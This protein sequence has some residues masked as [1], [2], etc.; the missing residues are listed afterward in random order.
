MQEE[1]LPGS[2]RRRQAVLSFGAGPSSK[3]GGSEMKTPRSA[4]GAK[5]QKTKAAEWLG[6]FL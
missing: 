1:A 5:E 2:C 3:G 4:Q 6:E